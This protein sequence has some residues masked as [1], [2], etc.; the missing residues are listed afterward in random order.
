MRTN[1]TRKSGKARLSLAAYVDR[2]R[3]KRAYGLIRI[4]SI[5]PFVNT[6]KPKS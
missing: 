2:G 5:P 6:P 3:L 1:A 4:V